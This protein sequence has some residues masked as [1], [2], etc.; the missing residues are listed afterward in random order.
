M[1]G[2]T[3]ITGASGF[4]G[5][6]LARRLIEEGRTSLR[7][8]DLNAK[9]LDP[10]VRE[11]AEVV[12]GNVLDTARLREAFRGVDVAYYLIHAVGAKDYENVERKSA[13]NFR[14][15]AI[16]E[17][18]RRIIYLGGLGKRETASRHLLS[19]LKTGEI[20][21][22]KPDKIQTI[23]FRAGIVIGAGSA[24][25]EI[26]RNLVEK[27]PVMI[28]PKWVSTKTEPIGIRDIVEYLVAARTA[29]F[30]ENLVVDVGIGPMSFGEMLLEAARVMGLRRFIIPVP[31]LTPNL[32]SYW[33]VLFTPVP[34]SLARELVLGLSSE[35]VKE[36]DNAARFFPEIRPA[37]YR[38][39]VLY[40]LSELEQQTVIGR[41]CDSLS[42]E[43]CDLAVPPVLREAVY[44]DER[45]FPL[46]GVHSQIVFNV[47]CEIGGEKGWLAN[48]NLWRL[49]GIIDKLLGG[50]GHQRGRRDPHDLRVG[51]AVDYWKVVDLVPGKRLLLLAEM[52][53]P[54]KAWL[55]F[56]ITDTHLIQRA[57]FLPR[58]LLGRTYWYASK[59]FHDRVF[60]ELGKE[61][62]AEAKKRLA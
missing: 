50:Y 52:K 16:A 9:A 40:A 53:L 26:I 10:V 58:G 2:K 60:S 61:I 27:L 44:R 23:W 30:K 21:S 62:I 51:D 46:D 28:T 54:G 25:F 33:L 5:R 7:V 45:I 31:L 14:D 36:N 48:N 39:A 17:G 13:E 15:C 55:E 47:I 20:L 41:W 35:T 22:S 49:R 34:F 19:R 6:R 18:V 38:E 42:K 43:V 57:I 32:S 29:E 8:F 4:I 11:K 3:L 12:E 37:P 59:P 24:S 1:E 56:Q